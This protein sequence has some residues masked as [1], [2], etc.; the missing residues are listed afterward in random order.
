MMDEAELFLSIKYG[1][2]MLSLFTGRRS[3]SW[4]CVGLWAIVAPVWSAGSLG[5]FICTFQAS[6]HAVVARTIFFAALVRFSGQFRGTISSDQGRRGK[7]CVV[8]M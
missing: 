1:M 8:E 3:R 5:R 7:Q 2:Y 4:R 6:F